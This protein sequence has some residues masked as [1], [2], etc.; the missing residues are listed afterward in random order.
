MS[1]RH[2][3]KERK[4]KRKGERKGAADPK[5]GTLNDYSSL[6]NC[7]YFHSSRPAPRV[8]RCSHRHSVSESIVTP[9]VNYLEAN[10][11]E[12]SLTGTDISLSIDTDSR[13]LKWNRDFRERERERERGGDHQAGKPDH[14]PTRHSA[15]NLISSNNP[16]CPLTQ[17]R[18][19]LFP[20]GTRRF[21]RHEFH[22]NFTII[23]PS[24]FNIHSFHLPSTT[25]FHSP[26]KTLYNRTNTIA[27][28]DRA[29]PSVRASSINKSPWTI[30]IHDRNW[31]A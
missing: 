30:V 16:R 9:L 1:T 27:T 11:A 12:S 17:I 18:W 2:S 19:S 3:Q 4:R 22:D 6:L 20:F 28:F 13:V 7:L 24:I 15:L 25:L 26:W 23:L 29:K 14:A 5:E 31:R 21:L 8:S 10:S